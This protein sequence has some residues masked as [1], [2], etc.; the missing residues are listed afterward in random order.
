M[1]VQVARRVIGNFILLYI[2]Q[3]LILFISKENFIERIRSPNEPE[4][5]RYGTLSEVCFV[6]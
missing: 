4:F 3:Q 5:E 6:K 1:P 2:T